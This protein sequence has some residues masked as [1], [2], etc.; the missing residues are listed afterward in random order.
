M[1]KSVPN[2]VRSLIASNV[3][4]KCD[5][6]SQDDALQK[7]YRH[8]RPKDDACTGEENASCKIQYCKIK[9]G[10]ITLFVLVPASYVHLTRYVRTMT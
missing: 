7:I 1:A 10:N 8:R 5:F 9:R 6:K 4:V 2:N 3:F